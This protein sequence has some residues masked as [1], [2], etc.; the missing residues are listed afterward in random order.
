[1]RVLIDSNVLFSAVYSKGSVPHQAFNKAVEPPY[2][3][4]ICKQSIVELRRAYNKKFPDKISA[5]E[6]FISF[7]LSVVE[8]VPIPHT[9]HMEED[10][11]RDAD[12]RPILRAAIKAGADIIVTGDKDFLDSSVTMPTIMTA[13]Q[14]VQSG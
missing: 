13:A 2:Q 7:V 6:Q 8:V 14:F 10:K 9:I 11:I 3:C 12:D 4:L 5:L 1:M